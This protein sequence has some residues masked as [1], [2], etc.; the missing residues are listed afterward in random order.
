[1]L[2]SAVVG[3]IATGVSV[4]K[5][6]FSSPSSALSL[7][8]RTVP[9]ILRNTT[10]VVVIL[11]I[12]GC[13]ASHPAVE[14]NGDLV[15]QTGNTILGWILLTAGAV[16]GLVFFTLIGGLMIFMLLAEGCI[17]N[18]RSRRFLQAG[19]FAMLA[20]VLASVLGWAI[21]SIAMLSLFKYQS[22]VVTASTQRS[23]LT[24]ER[25]RLLGGNETST[26]RY[27][28]ISAVD[29]EYI[30][31]A[32]GEQSIP[33]R[34]VVSLLSKGQSTPVFDG[35]PC[36]ARDLAN[37]IETAT[38]VQLRVHSGIRDLSGFGPFFTQ[39]R[40]GIDQ[41]FQVDDWRHYPEQAWRVLDF[42]FLWR[43]P[44]GFPVV[45]AEVGF[46]A[47]V[48][49]MIRRQRESD[50]GLLVTVSVVGVAVVGV[51]L[52]NIFATWSY[53]SWPAALA[54]IVLIAL[55]VAKRVFRDT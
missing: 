54:L 12:S 21:Y 4:R 44:W 29:F 27:A 25:Q 15:V 16:L 6:P 30:P 50:S 36:P 53:G 34:G 37:A 18:V 49:V 40:C 52:L 31:G 55:F 22:T 35:S 51:V 10:S 32:A 45:I 43:W 46:I 1:V 24:V 7:A 23:E 11:G 28:D 17:E 47:L 48:L 41:P 2:D 19:G 42:P 39:L 13:A 20:L 33:P 14:S 8:R 5:R 26:W 9:R 3:D 38:K